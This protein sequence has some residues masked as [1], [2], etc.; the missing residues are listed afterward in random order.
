MSEIHK[1]HQIIEDTRALRGYGAE[2]GVDEIYRDKSLRLAFMDPVQRAV[3]LRDFDNKVNEYNEN[4]T[5]RQKAQAFRFRQHLK[6]AH[7]RLKLA[8]R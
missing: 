3:T 2:V 1:P 7:E 4:C 5:L 6:T 8:G